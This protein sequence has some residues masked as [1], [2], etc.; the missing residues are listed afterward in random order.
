MNCL[1][2]KNYLLAFL[3]TMLLSSC[4]NTAIQLDE[5]DMRSISSD[6]KNFSDDIKAKQLQA[7]PNTVNATAL[8]TQDIA[9]KD[10][11]D[12]LSK[13]AQVVSRQ[14]ATSIG[15]EIER[16]ARLYRQNNKSWPSSFEILMQW[17]Q[18]HQEKTIITQET[19]SRIDFKQVEQALLIEYVLRNTGLVCKRKFGPKPL[20]SSP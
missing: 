13:A 3:L 12:S 9:P 11:G 7:V 18:E 19:F 6:S 14:S 4:S 1:Y 2:V 17:L 10:I 15:N 8:H 20:P 5:K 16:L